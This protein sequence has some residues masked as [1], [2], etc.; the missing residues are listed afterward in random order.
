M[1]R[2]DYDFLRRW[3]KHYAAEFGMDAL[4]I[5]NHGNDPVV[6]EIATGCSIIPIP[7]D[8]DDDFDS[9]RWK[10]LTDMT[11]ALRR[12]YEYVIVGDVDELLVVDPHLGLTLSEFINKRKDG[13]V[14]TPVGLEVVHRP[15]EEKDL[16]ND[17]VI[18]PRRYVRYSS[19]FCKPCI[20]GRDVR[21]SRGGHYT[22]APGLK[23]FRNLYLFHLKFA[24]ADTYLETA[25]RRHKLAT[26]VA[27][28]SSQSRISATWF[29]D[30]AEQKKRVSD[31]AQMKVQDEF[32]FSAHIARM[33]NTWEP[34]NNV[35]WHF[36]KHVALELH[37]IPD[38]FVGLI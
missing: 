13:M 2:D 4:Y 11:T 15:Q 18:G 3:I 22:S 9:T 36:K 17:A 1:V 26:S 29:A 10:F 8:F 7:G 5:V 23:V 30:S 31:L 34:R 27:G 38:R 35:Y 20:I 6:N 25:A 21:I 28:D 14:L 24:D 32:D 19:Y 33:R 16:M 12:Y 37:R